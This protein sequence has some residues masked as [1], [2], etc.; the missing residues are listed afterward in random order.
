MFDGPGRSVAGSVVQWA[1]RSGD[2]GL[3]GGLRRSGVLRFQ[4]D[5]AMSG[6]LHSAAMGSRVLAGGYG[7]PGIVWL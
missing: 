2:R 4:I 7:G 1:G 6:L 5:L 3:A